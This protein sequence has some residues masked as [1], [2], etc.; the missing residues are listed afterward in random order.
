MYVTA[1]RLRSR[2]SYSG[3]SG[4]ADIYWSSGLI[5]KPALTTMDDASCVKDSASEKHST[6]HV[7]Q[8]RYNSAASHLM[9]LQC[10]RNHSKG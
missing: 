1:V 6:R 4:V 3:N 2:V 5:N 7:T 10:W 9:N 8:V